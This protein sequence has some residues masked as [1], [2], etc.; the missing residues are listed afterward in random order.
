MVRF[1]C[2]VHNQYA[3]PI[4]ALSVFVCYI[5]KYSPTRSVIN[6]DEIF[7]IP[8]LQSGENLHWHEKFWASGSNLSRKRTYK[9][10]GLIVKNRMKVVLERRTVLITDLTCT[11]NRC[12][13]IIST[14]CKHSCCMCIH[15]GWTAVVHNLC[16][17]Y[18]ETRLNSLKWYFHEVRNGEVIPT[19]IVF[20][21]E[22]FFLQIDKRTVRIIG[23]L[24]QSKHCP[25]CMLGFVFGVLCV[26]LLLGPF[27]LK[28]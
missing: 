24:C 4:E 14:E 28:S 17:S 26:Q 2:I 23:F 7:I 5:L 12:V 25:Y 10:H 19:H 13:W 11:V 6:W 16:D 18:S 22:I 9:S 1:V 3:N 27:L 15:C 20:T 21:G 8:L